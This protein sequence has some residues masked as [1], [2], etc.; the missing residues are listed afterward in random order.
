MLAKIL[1][2]HSSRDH[3]VGGNTTSKSSPTKSK[4]SGIG[5]GNTTFN[6]SN[7]S[8]GSNINSA[9]SIENIRFVII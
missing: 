1:K 9:V 6:S 8:N 4:T 5:L 3:L 2:R 7:A